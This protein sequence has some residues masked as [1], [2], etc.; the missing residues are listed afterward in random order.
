MKVIFITREGYQ[1]SGSR[2][3]CH[4]FARQLKKYAVQTEVFSFADNLGAKYAEEESEMSLAKK[5]KYNFI[6]FKRLIKEDKNTIFF[7]QRLNYHVLAPVLVNL[8]HKNKLIFDCD[9]WNI[10]ENPKYYLGIFPSSKMEY[11][12]RKLAQ[13]AQLCI[14]ASKFLKSYLEPFSKKIY[15]L[16]TGVD[17]D[18][19]YPQGEQNSE[20]IVF[21][22]MGTVYH[23]PMLENLNFILSCFSEL[24]GEF[25]NIFF[26][27]AG[28]GKYYEEFKKTVSENRFSQRI[29]VLPWIPPEGM[30][31]FL[32]GIDIGLLPLIQDSYFNKAK[33]PTKM[34]EYMAMEKPVIASCIGEAKN[35]IIDGKTGLLASSRVEFISKMRLLI[36]DEKLRKYIGQK[37]NKEVEAK[38]SLNILGKELYS[39]IKGF[40]G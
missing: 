2:V 21:S 25:S 40:S 8:L 33:S 1:L 7:L 15:Y 24:A 35:I 16:P 39:I 5:L 38:Y 3:R 4:G 30:P 19:F 18:H 29:K 12:Y 9:D 14:T 28:Q 32:S 10:R 17:T 34:F 26:H 11:A 23:Q 20:K 13:H 37:A 36:L 27:L 31:Q 6:V 22:W